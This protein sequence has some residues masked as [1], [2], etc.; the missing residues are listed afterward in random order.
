MLF[1]QVYLTGQRSESIPVV[2][3]PHSLSLTLFSRHPHILRARSIESVEMFAA[4]SSLS[5]VECHIR[6]PRGSRLRLREHSLQRNKIKQG[7]VQN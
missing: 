4:G 6:K 1:G 5:P 7:S 3:R 2:E